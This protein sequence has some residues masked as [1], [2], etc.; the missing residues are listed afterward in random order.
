M[1]GIGAVGGKETQMYEEQLSWPAL[2]RG[3]LLLLPLPAILVLLTAP[4]GSAP[5]APQLVPVV[6]I[7]GIVAFAWSATTLRLRVDPTGVTIR[8]GLLGEHI[9]HTRIVAWAPTSYRWLQWGGFGV[10]WRPGRKLY[11]VPGDKGQA[12][13]LTL[14]TGQLVLCSSRDPAA[15]CRALDAL[16]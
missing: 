1:K 15:V 4:R 11:N 3:L 2:P 6:V 14:D 13:Q 12:V 8:M 5:L 10:R 7:L 16:R 9:P